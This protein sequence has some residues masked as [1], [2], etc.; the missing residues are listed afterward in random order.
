MR[1]GLLGGTFNPIHNG[2]LI[3][4][5]QAREALDLDRV[6]FIPTASPPHKPAQSILSGKDRL[7]LVREAVKGNSAF[8]VSDIELKRGGISY[9]LETVQALHKRFP[10]W[11]LFIIIGQD[12]LAVRWR[13]W[14]EILKICRLGVAVRP[15]AAIKIKPPA[16]PI[17]MPPIG[18]SS[19]E[20]RSRVAAGQ[21]I[22]YLVPNAVE[23]LIRRR[24][25]FKTQK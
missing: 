20:I 4:A 18:I 13:G 10:G 9:T 5:E 12:M 21:S 3:L 14:D 1:V 11:K 22:R 24:G 25:W 15:D 16:K 19:S 6:L 8:A 23:D 7:R 2:H 17:P